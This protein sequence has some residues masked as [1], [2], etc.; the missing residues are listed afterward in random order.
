MSDDSTEQHTKVNA[1]ENFVAF[2]NGRRTKADV[3]CVGEHAQ[4]AAIVEL[5]ADDPRVSRH[6][7]TRISADSKSIRLSG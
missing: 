3:V 1:G 7:R 6:S 4:S 2:G 5:A